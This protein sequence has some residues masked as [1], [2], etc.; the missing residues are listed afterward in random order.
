VAAFTLPAH[1][2]A[3]VITAIAVAAH[4][5]VSAT[6]NKVSWLVGLLALRGPRDWDSLCSTF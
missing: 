4:N 6:G 3:Y 2:V 1:S 5:N